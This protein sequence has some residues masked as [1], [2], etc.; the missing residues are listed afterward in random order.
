[1]EGA[2]K[3]AIMLIRLGLAIGG[4]W[5]LGWILFGL[6]YFAFGGGAGLFMLL[7]SAP[8]AVGGLVV[9]YGLGHLFHWVFTGR[10]R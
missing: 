2:L 6:L 8:V 7:I 5:A 4:L 3:G 10:W 1:M 9:F